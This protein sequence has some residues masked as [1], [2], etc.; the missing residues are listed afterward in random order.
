VASQ[1]Q[2]SADLSSDLPGNV[3]ILSL[4]DGIYYELEEVGARIWSLIQKPC[5][6]QVILD[7]LLKE[8]E[9]DAQRCEA[10]LLALVEEM[11]KRGLIEIK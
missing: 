7:T 4:K 3:V 9:V 2:I 6:I 1:N 5:S 10:D 8:Y 11:T